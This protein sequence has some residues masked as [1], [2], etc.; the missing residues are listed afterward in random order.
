MSIRE[1]NTTTR[2]QYSSNVT[3]PTTKE[4]LRFSLQAVR[5]VYNDPF[6]HASIA[7]VV[8]VAVSVVPCACACV[9]A[10]SLPLSVALP[11]TF[12][13]LFHALLFNFCFWSCLLCSVI[14]AQW[15]YTCE[16]LFGLSLSVFI[17]S[18]VLVCFSAAFL[19]SMWSPCVCARVLVCLNTCAWCRREKKM[20]SFC[21]TSPV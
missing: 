1:N 6:W 10:Y 17:T 14:R 18:V 12:W 16:W 13:P 4:I 9:Y 8:A 20:L 11:F 19:L 21:R 3:V 5:F 7:I 15:V 2:K